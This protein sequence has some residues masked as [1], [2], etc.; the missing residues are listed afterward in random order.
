MRYMKIKPFFLYTFVVLSLF[1]CTKQKYAATFPYI[2]YNDSASWIVFLVPHNDLFFDVSP[3]L[4]AIDNNDT[5]FFSHYTILREG[6]GIIPIESFSSR[7]VYSGYKKLTDIVPQDTVRIFICD[8]TTIY[9]T[10]VIDIS[11]NNSILQRYDL[12]VENL[13]SLLD[14]RGCLVLHWPPD[15]RMADMKMFPPYEEIK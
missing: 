9:D 10:P 7:K 12:T 3:N 5:T 2:F 6:G 15:S 13:F 14:K 11:A 1:S 8:Y 4:R